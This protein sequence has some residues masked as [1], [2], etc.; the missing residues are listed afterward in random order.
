MI[1]KELLEEF[2]SFLRDSEI[3]EIDNFSIDLFLKHRATDWESKRIQ[4]IFNDLYVGVGEP[5][6]H[7]N[8]LQAQGILKMVYQQEGKEDE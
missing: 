7:L 2:G 3:D 4:T 5:V 6:V 1:D 8:L